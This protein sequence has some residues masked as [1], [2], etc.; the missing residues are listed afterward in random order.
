MTEEKF[1]ARNHCL[2]MDTKENKSLIYRIRQYFFEK[3]E[4]WNIWDFVPYRWSMYYYD[5]IKPIFRPRNKR[6]RK[7]IPR[8]YSDI[9]E[10]IVKV[11]FEFIKAFYEDEYKADIVDW[12]ATEEH[13]NFADWLEKA[14]HYITVERPNL[15]KQ[16]DAAYPPTKNIEDMFERIEQE[17]GTVVC[18]MKDDGIPYEVKYGEVN[19]LEQ[20]IDDNDKRYLIDMIL[21]KDYFW[22]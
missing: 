11:N 5:I 15:E 18:Y 10:L 4:I 3:F 13:Q 1:M 22:T 12:S 9:T 6:I 21:R 14:Y 17:D 19:R 2:K 8:Q 16:R 7:A 20:E